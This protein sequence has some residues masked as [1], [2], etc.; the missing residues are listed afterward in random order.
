MVVAYECWSSGAICIGG[1]DDH[2]EHVTVI[3][4]NCCRLFHLDGAGG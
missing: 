1:G 3:C 2:C 4:G